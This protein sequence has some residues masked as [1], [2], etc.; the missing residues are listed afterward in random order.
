MLNETT[1]DVIS[2]IQ[3]ARCKTGQMA[4]FLPDKLKGKIID[5][6]DAR[7]LKKT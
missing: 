2:G 5:G 7:R 1:G 6:R 3:T 4:Q